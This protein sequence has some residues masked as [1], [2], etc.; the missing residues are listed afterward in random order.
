MNVVGKPKPGRSAAKSVYYGAVTL[1]EAPM[2][3]M[4]DTDLFNVSV[5]ALLDMPFSTA[6]RH[7]LSARDA[8]AVISVVTAEDI[9][10]FGYRSVA[11]AL[12]QVP[13]MYGISDRVAPNVGV[14]GIHAGVRA[15]SRILKVMID[16]QPMAFRSDASNFLGPSLLNMEAVERIEVV[17]G[18]ASA[19]YGADAFL[20]VIN[21]ITRPGE[22]RHRALHAAYSAGG[23]RGPAAALHGQ[24]QQGRWQWLLSASAADL[25]R[26]D[27][28]LPASSPLYRRATTA[29]GTSRAAEDDTRPRNALLRLGYAAPGHDTTFTAHAYRLDSDAEFLDFGILSHR[30]R[31]ALY[32]RTLRLQHE[33][34]GWE[35][36]TLRAGASHA[37]GAPDTRERLSL[38]A[39]AS[40]PERAIGFAE[41]A[42]N[43]E[44]QRR[45]GEQHSIVLGF[46]RSRDSEE[47]M[48]I[49]SVDAASG[50]R[51]LLS[52]VE[53]RERITN[54]GAYL[55]YSVRPW[56][57]LGVTANLRRDR[58]SVFGADTNHRLAL[59]GSL[60]ATL[61]YKLL[62][63]TSY[64][65]PS[66]AQLYA[67]PLYAGEVLGNRAL[68]PE[69]SAST[70]ASLHWQATSTLAL[71]G[72]VY[73]L[74]VRDK[75]ELLPL[76]ANLQPQNS[77]RQ[78]G[79]GW[80]G[81][82]LWQLGAQ[83][84]RAQLAWADTDDHFQPRL[85]PLQVTP[86]A[87]YPR[88]VARLSWQYLHAG[89]GQ[90]AV[91]ARHVSPRRASKANSQENLLRPYQ[92]ASYALADVN[93]QR[94]LGRHTLALRV[95]NLFDRQYA[96]PGYGGIDLP[97]DSRTVTVGYSYRF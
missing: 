3:V 27:I 30:N 67:Q 15:W 43:L 46:D 40:Y 61:H 20:G 89:L 65:A 10:Q 18:P 84:W 2:L 97:G 24:G 59:V 39:S 88:L 81:E 68:R 48:R 57:W 47:R 86:T 32:Q 80:E 66:A 77:G 14:R 50:R 73:K 93:W 38:G 75:T 8:P 17:R 71:S 29:A 13:G 23:E 12:V 9:R 79:K 58:H 1:P 44:A 56:S 5:E 54:S 25:E 31:L 16:G 94:S 34:R 87:S 60:S 36:W 4:L 49:Y 69:T 53:A 33:Y 95:S 21:I 41:Q 37:R 45:L 91:S 85:Q 82:A 55:Q 28:A 11:E 74:T 6:S 26:D 7:T 96:E 42:F 78:E 70:E 72:N 52:G 62:H 22:Q 76:G 83:R 64:K 19:L 51:T 90:F 63:G 35:G 92:L